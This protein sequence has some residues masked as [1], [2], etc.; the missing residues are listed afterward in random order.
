MPASPPPP[1]R[2]LPQPESVPKPIRRFAVEPVATSTKSNRPHTSRL[3]AANTQFPI[4]R[5]VPQVE[6]FSVKSTRKGAVLRSAQSA[7]P[8]AA[9][10]TISTSSIATASQ[11]TREKTT[12]FV[13]QLIETTRRSRKSGDTSPALLSTDKTD[14]S[15]GDSVYLP[16]HLRL[17]QP[18]LPQNGSGTIPVLGTL[19][20]P[21][22]TSRFSSSNLSRNTPR[23]PSFR[24]PHLDPIRSQPESEESNESTC[25]S[26][27]TST[28]V[29]PGE[30][31]LYKHAS[32]IRES[33]DDR[34]SG[35]LLAL[36]ARAAEKQLRDQAMA[37]YPNENLHEPVDHFAIDR[38]SDTS[39][40][41]TGLGMLPQDTKKDKNM[42]RRESAA[43]WDINEMRRHRELLEQQN[44]RQEVT[45]Q[46]R[47]KRRSKNEVSEDTTVIAEKDKDTDQVSG[48]TARDHGITQRGIGLERMRSAASP[49]MLGQDLTFPLCRSPQQTRIDATQ[50][51]ISRVQG[52][53]RSRQYSGLWTPDEARSR[54]SSAGGLWHGVCAAS[55]QALLFPAKILPTGLMTPRCE[56]DD[57]FFKLDIRANNQSTPFPTQTAE[58][59]NMEIDDVLSAQRSI[60]EEF[61]DGFVT[62]IYNYLSLGYPS[63]A[64][65]Y[66]N[67]LSKIS[68]VSLEEIRQND[69]QA[70]TKGFIGAPEGSGCDEHEVREGQCGRWKALRLYIQEWARQQSGMMAPNQGANSGWGVWARKGS[71]AI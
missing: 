8:A 38:E 31:E 53:T 29:S 67:E 30:K 13:P 28:S 65:K 55:D 5:F 16:R 2:R 42:F 68:K 4:R 43:G 56:Q 7:S 1:L 60:E 20:A 24:V 9:Q 58:F 48:P 46:P 69:L 33:C 62:Q 32:R 52:E 23:Q 17:A 71:W 57:P 36:A 61:H 40:D 49:P 18:S 27:S 64:Q 26:L 66:D 45:E 6:E 22:S 11:I 44:Q 15:P 25:P 14:L 50:H 35:Y 54:Q 19:D 39:E 37:A 51:P 12:R 34:F 63:L 41:E 70:N 3:E 21:L 47:L 10:R 59:E